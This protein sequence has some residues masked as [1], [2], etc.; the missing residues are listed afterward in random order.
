MKI[1]MVG[2]AHVTV[3]ELDDAGRLLDLVEEVVEL[4]KPDIVVFMGDQHHN[5]AV[6]RIEVLDFW[7]KRLNRLPRKGI[8]M[9]VGN[10]DRSTNQTLDMNSLA[11]DCNVI[12]KLAS[13][14][15]APRP[16]DHV[17]VDDPNWPSDVFLMPWVPDA[18]FA[19]AIEAVPDNAILLCHQTFNGAMYENGFYAP[20]GVD[21]KIVA[22]FKRVFSGHIH[23]PQSFANIEYVGAPRWRIMSDANERRALVLYDTQIHMKKYFDTSKHCTPILRLEDREGDATS[24][25]SI[26]EH[27]RKYVDIFGSS[28]YCDT[29]KPIWEEKGFAVATFPVRTVSTTVSESQGIDRALQNHLEEFQ[30]PFG[31]SKEVL[32]KMVAERI[33][34]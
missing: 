18:Q 7:R 3:D 33:H 13:V 1:L 30:P 20:D 12:R 23:K 34:V 16:Y 8:F 29:R 26:P 15:I 19:K 17:S 2:D 21:P 10:H 24:V 6:V 27:A 28:A 32:K 31:T 9:L 22:R 5:H 4:E 11:Y 25:D 14:C